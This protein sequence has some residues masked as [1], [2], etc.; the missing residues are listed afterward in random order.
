MQ[1]GCLS[2]KNQLIEPFLNV[3]TAKFFEEIFRESLV[4]ELIWENKIEYKIDNSIRHEKIKKTNFFKLVRKYLSKK[5]RN[6]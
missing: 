1:A 6:L 5:I 3:S 4:I 2:K